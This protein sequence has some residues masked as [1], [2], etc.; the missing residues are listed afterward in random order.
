MQIPPPFR[1]TCPCRTAEFFTWPNDE[2]VKANALF[3]DVKRGSGP[4]QSLRIDAPRGLPYKPAKLTALITRREIGSYPSLRYIPRAEECGETPREADLSSEQTGAQAPSRF[5]FP[6]VDQR[7]PQGRG[8]QARARPQ[9]PQ[10][11]SLAREPAS[12]HGTIEA[13]CGLPGRRNRY[14]G[15]FDRVRAASPQAA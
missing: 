3:F 12:F 5:P 4:T 9:A 10:R 14:E 2:W 7:R 13:T 11:L 1:A 8:R 6:H 15:S